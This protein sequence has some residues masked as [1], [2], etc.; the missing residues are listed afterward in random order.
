MN[1]FHFNEH[2]QDTWKCDWLIGHIISITPHMYE[3]LQTLHFT[4]LQ[5]LFKTL[6]NNSSMSLFYENSFEI[7]N[8]LLKKCYKERRRKKEKGS[9]KRKKKREI[10][11]ENK[12]NKLGE[13]PFF[14]HHH[15]YH[16]HLSLSSI[17]IHIN[18]ELNYHKWYHLWF[19][20]SI[21]F[22]CIFAFNF[23]SATSLLHPKDRNTFAIAIFI[24]RRQVEG[25]SNALSNFHFEGRSDVSM[26]G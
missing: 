22:T 10:R 8:Y 16:F 11:S 4:F 21:L 19:L 3:S 25:N 23:P 24:E 12:E 1:E 9:R 13:Y 5:T 14:Y 26:R 18:W 17:I 2:K 6:Q 20:K 15:L 7:S